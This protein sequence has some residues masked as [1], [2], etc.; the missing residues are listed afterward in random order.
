MKSVVTVEPSP[1]RSLARRTLGAT[2][3]GESSS[4]RGR[5]SPPIACPSPLGRDAPTTVAAKMRGCAG[6]SLPSQRIGWVPRR[7]HG[8]FATLPPAA[9][10]L[11]G[12]SGSVMDRAP[13]AASWL[14]GAV[15][16]ASL[17][18]LG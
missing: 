4:I 16:A 5:T 15:V 13:G 18:G 10:G 8:E 7:G 12:T 17:L 1:W 6:D 11:D 14:R 9:G 3:A 2:I